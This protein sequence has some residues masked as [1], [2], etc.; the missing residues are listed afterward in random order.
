[1][2][3][4]LDHTLDN[5]MESFFLAETIKYLYL[6]FDPTNPLL[7]P[8]QNAKIQTLNDK[9]KCVLGAGE[10]FSHFHTVVCV[11]RA[12]SWGPISLWLPNF[13]NIINTR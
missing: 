8:L 6:L 5:R 7:S 3:N 12:C 13:W 11:V 2:K 10:L 1:M 4:V 9:R